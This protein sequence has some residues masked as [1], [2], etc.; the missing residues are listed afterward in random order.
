MNKFRN[1]DPIPFLAYGLFAL[2]GLS[3]LLAVIKA[4][5]DGT[6]L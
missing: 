5:F 1:F 3:F 4:C 2:W 6:A